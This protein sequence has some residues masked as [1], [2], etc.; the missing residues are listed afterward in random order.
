MK[1]KSGFMIGLGETRDE[2]ICTMRDLREVACDR[3]TIGQYLQPTPTHLPVIWYLPPEVFAEYRRV[4]LALGFRHVESGPLV[5]SSY[6]A[7][8]QEAV[9]GD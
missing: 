7:E 2:V 9:A 3:L 6:H 4:G 1:T 5:R 8:L